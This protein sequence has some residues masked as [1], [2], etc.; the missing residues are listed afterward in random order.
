MLSG[1]SS[2]EENDIAI[3]LKVA[4]E[5]Q[6]SREQRNLLMAIRCA[7]NGGRGREYGVLSVK[8]ETQYDQARVTA[9]S[10]LN[11]LRRWEEAGRPGQFVEFMCR[12]WCPVGAQNDPSGLNRHWVK[13][14][15]YYLT[16]L[17]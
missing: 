15:Q 1:M 12:R 4:K 16:S 13:N 3:A 11:N 7:E 6:L 8:A 14:V 5:L 17:E 10:I 9:R 2:A